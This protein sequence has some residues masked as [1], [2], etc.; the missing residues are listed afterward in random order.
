MKELRSDSNNLQSDGCCDSTK[1][2]TCC[3]PTQSSVLYE[4]PTCCDMRGFLS[5]QI[6]WLISKI[7]PMHGQEIAEEL[8]KRRGF[9]PSPGT[10]YPALKYLKSPRIFT[11]KPEDIKIVKPPLIKG[12]KQGRKIIYQLADGAQEELE[13]ACQYFCQVFVDIF[14]EYVGKSL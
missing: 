14:E 1:A 6:L 11:K 7:G 8:H 13:Q 5:F 2:S 4:I 12:E 9:K 10:L 3:D